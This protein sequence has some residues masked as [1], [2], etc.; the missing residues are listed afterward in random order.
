MQRS[1]QRR[2]PSA[3]TLLSNNRSGIYRGIAPCDPC[4]AP[5]NNSIGTSFGTL[6]RWASFTG[7]WQE[8]SNLGD[9]SGYSLRSTGIIAGFDRKVSRNAFAGIAFGYDNAYQKFDTIP[10][11]NQ[12]NIFRTILYGGIKSGTTYADG[13]AG[14][15]KNWHKTRR[16]ITIDTFEAIA[17]SKYH[18]N[19]LS[20][21]FE[22]GRRL[23]S[24]LTPSIGLH[25]REPLKIDSLRPLYN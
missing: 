1:F 11:N 3:Y 5:C 8:R 15:T 18:D 16:D 14:Y 22:I 17:Q 6:N 23:P 24:G 21:G 7:G 25:Y 12:M 10:A 13:Y 19:L 20:T 2:L 9:F 4:S